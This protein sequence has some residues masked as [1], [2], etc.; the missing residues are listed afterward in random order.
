MKSANTSM[1]NHNKFCGAGFDSPV[2]S[3]ELQSLHKANTTADKSLSAGQKKHLT[4][5]QHR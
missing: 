3:S 1:L 2:S 4:K 5:S